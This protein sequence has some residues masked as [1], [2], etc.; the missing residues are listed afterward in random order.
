MRTLETMLTDEVGLLVE[1]RCCQL[2]LLLAC[3]DLVGNLLLKLF[4]ISIEVQVTS[5]ISD[6]Y[7]ILNQFIHLAVHNGRLIELEFLLSNAGFHIC[8]PSQLSLSVSL[9]L[10]LCQFRVF[11]FLFTS[12]TLSIGL[13]DHA[14]DTLLSTDCRAGHKHLVN[15]GVHVDREILVFNDFLVPG[16]SDR[17]DPSLKGLADESVY[18]IGHITPVQLIQLTTLRRRSIVDFWIVFGKIQ[19]GFNA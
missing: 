5:I 17:V 3:L 7:A 12:A 8:Y 2:G 1:L 10:L 16:F 11:D 19:H 15:L 13:H 4:I 18:H 9:F 6:K 14:T